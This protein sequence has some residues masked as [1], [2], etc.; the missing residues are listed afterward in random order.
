[1]LLATA[2]APAPAPDGATGGAGGAGADD[3]YVLVMAPAWKDATDHAAASYL[4]IVRDRALR[5]L[6]DLG[7]AQLPML[8]A[9]RCVC[10]VLS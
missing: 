10:G 3:G 5:S 1:M 8:R 2:P 4:A 9:L 7:P 6:R